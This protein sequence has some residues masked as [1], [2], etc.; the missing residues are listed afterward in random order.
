MDEVDLLLEESPAPFSVAKQV[1][2]ESHHGL[3]ALLLLV[4]LVGDL[5]EAAARRVELVGQVH[6]LLGLALLGDLLV[7]E[8]KNEL[9]KC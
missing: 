7:P 6:L 5:L 1:P 4:L 8:P 2:D 3:E 9:R